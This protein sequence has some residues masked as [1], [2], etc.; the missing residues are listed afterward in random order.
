M[1]LQ[2]TIEQNDARRDARAA[3]PRMESGAAPATGKARQDESPRQRD[4]LSGY[5]AASSLQI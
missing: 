1:P 4:D 2:R 3:R 5:G